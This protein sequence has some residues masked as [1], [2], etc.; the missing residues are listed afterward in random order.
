[1]TITNTLNLADGSSATNVFMTVNIHT[2]KIETTGKAPVDLSFWR[3]EADRD[4]GKEKII[5]I[6]N[7][8]KIGSCVLTFTGSEIVKVGANCTV[9]DTFSYYNGQ[10]AAKLLALYGWDITL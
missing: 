10:V 5:P 4:A 9:S 1:M 8:N 3:S 7:G 2:G 6:V